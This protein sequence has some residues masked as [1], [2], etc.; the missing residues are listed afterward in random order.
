MI[1]IAVLCSLIAALVAP[2]IPADAQVQPFIAGIVKSKAGKPLP[3]LV[4][5]EKGEIHWYGSMA[6][7]DGNLDVQRAYLTV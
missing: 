3:G 2:A 5:L 1:R 6:Q 7:L 4:L